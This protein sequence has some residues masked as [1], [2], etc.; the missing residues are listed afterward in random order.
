MWLKCL[1]FL[2]DTTVL[3]RWGKEEIIEFEDNDLAIFLNDSK[4]FASL[5]I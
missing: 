3:L 5:N 2:S 1:C 4:Y